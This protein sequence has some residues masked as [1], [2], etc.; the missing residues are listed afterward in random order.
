VEIDRDKIM[1]LEDRSYLTPKLVS[2]LRQKNITVLSHAWNN[3]GKIGLSTSWYI[4]GDIGLS[5]LL[6]VEWECYCNALNNSGV[7]IID[8]DDTLMWNEG[9]HFMFLSAKN[10]YLAILST[11]YCSVIDGWRHGIWKWTIQLKI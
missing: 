2:C 4:F 7:S 6:V 5:G 10:V 3:L 8:G 11:Q 9:D 1:G